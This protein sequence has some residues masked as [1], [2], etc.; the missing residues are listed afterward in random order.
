MNKTKRIR[1][2]AII[3]YNDRIVSMYREYKDRKYYT[4]PGGGKEEY[5]TEEECVIR[6]VY[7]E[8]GIN[9]KVIRKVYVYEKENAIEH[10]YIADWIDG[11]FGSGDGEEYQP[12]NVMGLY[13]PTLINIKD[14]PS[15]P[16]MPPE[17]AKMFY[18]DYL[19]NGKELRK[20]VIKIYEEK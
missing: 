18:S 16:L 17:V 20:N 5:E 12:D 8:F 6:E 10:Y 14:I 9:V 2:A 3:F 7:E 19:E 15:L 1:G 13:K 4:F 11:D